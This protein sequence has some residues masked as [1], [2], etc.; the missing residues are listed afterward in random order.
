MKNILVISYAFPPAAY[1][2][3]YRTLKYC[4]YLPSYGWLPTVLTIKSKYVTFSD[5]SII[6]D[7]PRYISVYRTADLDLIRWWTNRPRNTAA[8]S[9]SVGNFRGNNSYTYLQK[10]LSGFKRRI[11]ELLTRPDSHVFWVPIALVKGI[12]ILLSKR[13]DVVYCSS[14]PH[15]SHMIALLLAK[16]FW[17]PYVTDF[18]DPWL[19]ADS[20]FPWKGQKGIGARIEASLKNI[21]VRNASRIITA[22]PGECDELMEQYRELKQSRFEFITNGYDP[23]DFRKLNEGN[24]R[25][26]K[27]VISHTGTIYNGT[28]TEFFEGVRLLLTR[29]PDLKA[30]IEINLVGAVGAEYIEMIQSTELVDVCKVRGF[31]PHKVA[32]E[33]TFKSDVLVVLLGGNLFPSSEIPAKVF[34]YLYTGKPILSVTREGDLSRLLSRSGLGVCVSPDHVEGVADEIWNIYQAKC[35]GKAIVSPNWEYIKSFERKKLSEKLAPILE[36]VI[37]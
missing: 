31:Q 30:L 32:L 26:K 23:D 7:L 37:Q 14:P 3:V 34:E 8:G 10:L 15:S 12:W 19:I 11:I 16:L 29:Y 27:F 1:V 4:K 36:S 35:L 13:I 18:R 5:A 25:S 22:S 2:G 17:L 24:G 33:Y 20:Q 21:I 9:Q 28:A 6:D